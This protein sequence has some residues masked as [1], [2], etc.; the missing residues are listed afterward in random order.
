MHVDVAYALHSPRRFDRVCTHVQFNWT[1]VQ[2]PSWS[3]PP[4]FLAHAQAQ[5]QVQVQVH[6]QV[7]AKPPPRRA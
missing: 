3:P 4:L 7:H 6:A 2:S 1:T 5:V